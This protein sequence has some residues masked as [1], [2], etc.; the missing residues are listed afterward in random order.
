MSLYIAAFRALASNAEK[1][2]PIP[3]GHPSFEAVVAVSATSAQSAAIPGT[4]AYVMFARLR[5][6]ETCHIAIGTN[7]TA[8]TS[9][10]FKMEAG[11]VEWIGLK[12]GDKV[13]VIGA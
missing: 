3:V 8:T 13:A 4:E 10:A 6:D 1:T 7:P 12:A 5:A 2:A 9:N 11:S